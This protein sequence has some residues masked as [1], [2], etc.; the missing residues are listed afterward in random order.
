MMMGFGLV[1][2]LL[3]LLFWVLLIVGAIWL[4]KFIFPE[5]G[6]PGR[7]MTNRSS[8]ARDI[9]EMR[10]ARGEITRDQYLTMLEDI[11]ERAG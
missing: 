11:G 1:G 6:L 10:Y 5:D 4:V 8:S 7:R 2:L 3:M 9:L